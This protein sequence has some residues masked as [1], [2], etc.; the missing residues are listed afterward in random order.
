MSM[1][2]YINGPDASLLVKVMFYF[3]VALGALKI[4]IWAL[5]LLRVVY[6]DIFRRCLCK[7]NFMRKY[8]G[9]LG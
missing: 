3:V 9:K 6:V 4:F 7:P 2:S 8:G 5:A 1:L